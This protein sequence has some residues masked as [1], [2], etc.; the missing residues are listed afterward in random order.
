MEDEGLLRWEPELGGAEDRG[1]L[2][3]ASAAREAL[4]ARGAGGKERGL[5]K[6][7]VLGSRDGRAERRQAKRDAPETLGSKW[8]DLPAPR[9]TPELKTDLRVLKLRGTFD[10]KR[11]YKSHDDTKASGNWRWGDD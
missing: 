8:F 1:A 7:A 3:R 10:A 11:F 2:K 4:V 5:S 6:R 9:M